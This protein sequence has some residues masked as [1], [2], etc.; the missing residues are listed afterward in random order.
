MP[1]VLFSVSSCV[2]ISSCDIQGW[3][4]RGPL[5]MSLYNDILKG[6]SLLL[7]YSKLWLMQMDFCIPCLEMVAL[8][9]A[10][11]Y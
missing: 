2:A 11:M 8:N 1:F 4:E 5:P 3:G 10:T 7:L 6:F 9:E